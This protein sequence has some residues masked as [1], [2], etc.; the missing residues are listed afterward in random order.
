MDSE[1]QWISQGSLQSADH[2]LAND[3]PV[4]LPDHPEAHCI[5][6]RRIFLQDNEENEGSEAMCIC[7]EC[8]GM[9]FNDLEATVR[10]SHPRRLRRGRSRYR[11]S[12][13][14]EDLFSQQFSHLINLVRQNQNTITASIPEPDTQPDGDAALAV[15]HRSAS[16]TPQSRSRRWRRA[17]LSDNESEGVDNLDS[18]FGES[19]SN[20]SFGGY[21]PFTGESDGF[22]FSAYGGESDASVDAHSLLERE[23]FMQADDGSSMDSDT[24][25]DPMHVGMDRWNLDDEDEDGEWEE[26]DAEEDAADSTRVDGQIRDNNITDVSSGHMDYQIQFRFPGNSGRI[27]LRMQESRGTYNIPNVFANLEESEMTPPY[28]GNA[29]DYLDARGFE[30]LLEQ[31]AETDA[32]RRGAPPA[33]ASF[34]GS[35]PRVIIQKEHEKHGGLICAV[36]KDPLALDSEASQLPCSHLYHPSCIL[37]WLSTR[38]SCPVCRYELPTDDKDYEEGKRNLGIRTDIHEIWPQRD[39]SE[40][41]S[42]SDISSDAGAVEANESTHRRVEQ[43]NFSEMG[44]AAGSSDG[45]GG[46]RHRWF[47]LAAA[48]IV[49]IVGIALVLWFRNPVSNRQ[50]QCGFEGGP[51]HQLL[52]RSSGSSA[53]SPERRENRSRRWWSFF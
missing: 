29:G 23:M 16:H 25:I 28:V 31:L 37:P 15:L 9:F 42:S 35:L 20:V 2:A 4:H 1:S 41:D 6:C 27:R 49:S 52:P 7:R 8:K 19:D 14:I 5:L 17:P 51:E 38:N 12:E 21:G 18:L 3:S 33:A 50:A 26:A 10:D 45:E 48:P 36:C 44:H 47:F 34:V 46:R 53:G 22:S 30:E 24:D 43:G 11:S 39:L 32:S 40:D 13:S